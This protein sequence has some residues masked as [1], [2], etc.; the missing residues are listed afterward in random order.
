MRKS[1]KWKSVCASVL[2]LLSTGFLSSC[3]PDPGGVRLYRINKEEVQVDS[4]TTERLTSEEGRERFVWN[5]TA[6]VDRWGDFDFS[7]SSN[8]LVDID[9]LKEFTFLDSSNRAIE[10]TEHEETTFYEFYCSKQYI[11]ITPISQM[12]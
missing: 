3:D 8:G 1:T 4:T 9:E 7:F 10:I 6:P 11:S 2:F 5:R 12:P